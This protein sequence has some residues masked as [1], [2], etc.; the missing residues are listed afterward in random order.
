MEDIFPVTFKEFP[1]GFVE[2]RMKLFQIF[3][4]ALVLA[5]V[6]R[7]GHAIERR[8][9]F[10]GV[11]R[12]EKPVLGSLGHYVAVDGLLSP[13]EDRKAQ[14]HAVGFLNTLGSFF[15]TVATDDD[16]RLKDVHELRHRIPDIRL[17]ALPPGDVRRVMPAA[18][19]VLACLVK[20]RR[21]KINRAT[22]L[23]L[24]INGVALQGLE[25][26]HVELYSFHVLVDLL[27]LV[28]RVDPR[29]GEVVRLPKFSVHEKDCQ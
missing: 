6:G 29:H 16:F 18:V 10:Q 8:P 13:I 1:V 17:A 3:H 23:Q 21:H 20:A 9:F 22:V 24:P 26:L 4:A 5:V 12:L 25:V 7:A 2:P 15:S 14:L 19:D 11:P 27:K 28:A